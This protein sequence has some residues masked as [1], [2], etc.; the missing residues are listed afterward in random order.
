MRRVSENMA[1]SFLTS[2]EAVRKA[3]GVRCPPLSRHPLTSSQP[4]LTL[5]LGPGLRAEQSHGPARCSLILPAVTNPS[6]V[7]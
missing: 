6:T 2:G 5:G 3:L 1:L 7:V 4:F